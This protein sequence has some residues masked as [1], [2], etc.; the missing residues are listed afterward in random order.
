MRERKILIFLF[1]L[2]VSL[3]SGSYFVLRE[4]IK[5]VIEKGIDLYLKERTG[6]KVE[7]TSFSYKFPNRISFK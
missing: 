4:K 6:I 5:D 3:L 1:I 7:Y 2:I